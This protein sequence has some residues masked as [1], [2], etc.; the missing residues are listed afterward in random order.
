[1]SEEVINEVT[2]LLRSVLQYTGEL[3]VDMTR[4]DIPNWDSLRHVQVIEMLEREHNVRLSMD[5]MM[6]IQSVKDIVNVLN[7]HGLI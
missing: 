1:M 7:R 6:E 4:D 5:E 3:S 2:G